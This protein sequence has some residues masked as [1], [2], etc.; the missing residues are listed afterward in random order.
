MAREPLPPIQKKRGRPAGWHKTE[1]GLKLSEKVIGKL[2]ASY[3]LNEKVSEG[4]KLKFLD[5][6]VE[7]YNNLIS[8]AIQAGYITIDTKK[9]LASGAVKIAE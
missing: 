8:Q 5:V 3:V 2:F 1:S 6:D 7:K 9:A 4:D